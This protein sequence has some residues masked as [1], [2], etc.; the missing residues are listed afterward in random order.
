MDDFY[1]KMNILQATMMALTKIVL[2]AVDI[3]TDWILTVQLITGWGYDL[4]CG[5][6]FAEYHVNMG[7]AYIIPAVISALLHLH[8]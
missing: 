2:P 7:I 3:V 5:D 8:H 4:S 6:Y 1:R